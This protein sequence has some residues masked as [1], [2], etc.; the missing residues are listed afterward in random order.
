MRR[1]PSLSFGPFSLPIGRKESK[2]ENESTAIAIQESAHTQGG[3]QTEVYQSVRKAKTEAYPR[4]IN[5]AVFFMGV[6]VCHSF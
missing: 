1:A 2:Y 5:Q 3:A 4:K 6:L